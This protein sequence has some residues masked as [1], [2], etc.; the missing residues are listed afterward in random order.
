MIMIAE[1]RCSNFSTLLNLF[2]KYLKIL[3]KNE[4]LPIN[5]VASIIFINFALTE[6]KF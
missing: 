2:V 5:S 3:F 6:L 4:V 1:F